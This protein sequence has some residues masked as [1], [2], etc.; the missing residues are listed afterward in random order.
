MSNN[1]YDNDK[2]AFEYKGVQGALNAF[3]QRSSFA[4]ARTPLSLEDK[5][6]PSHVN[7]NSTSKVQAIS[8]NAKFEGKR[9]SV[10]PTGTVNLSRFTPM[11]P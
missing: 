6:G 3:V 1:Q 7:A 4:R 8:R 10:T 2:Q 11:Q 9:S 5:Y